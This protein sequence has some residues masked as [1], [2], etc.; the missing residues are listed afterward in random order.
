[1]GSIVNV[2]SSKPTRN[3]CINGQF[4][5]FQRRVPPI[6]NNE[7]NLYTADRWFRF[8]QTGGGAG[9]FTVIQDAGLGNGSRSIRIGR[10]SGS[11][12]LNSTEI[13]QA[14]E[15]KDSLEL[16]GKKVT[17][18]FK[19]RKG[20]NFSGS[21][22]NFY[23][24]YGTGT[25][26]GVVATW[27]GQGTLNGTAIPAASLSTTTYYQ[28]S[29]TVTL[30]AISQLRFDI[31]YIPTGTA[32]ANDYIE[33]T[34]VMV[35]QGDFVPYVRAGYTYEQELKICQRYFEKSYN[36]DVNPLSASGPGTIRIIRP[37]G[38]SGITVYYKVPKRATPLISI[39]NPNV[40]LT[41]GIYRDN[42]ASNIAGTSVSASGLNSFIPDYPGVPAGESYSLHYIADAEL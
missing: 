39:Y 27:T 16:S 41:G 3:Y 32:G 33:I 21:Q 37:I 31:N 6:W 35:N 42:T 7:G 30:P 1:M 26:E 17:F 22:V 19:I 20:A 12:D 13:I 23:I 11:T 5:F 9:V 10:P 34:E 36:L 14:L 8:K 28:A 15:S 40:A 38:S 18:S 4:D 24:G 29:M 2:I 25:D